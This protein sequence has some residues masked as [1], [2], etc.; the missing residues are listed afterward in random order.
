MDILL[1]HGYFLY[2]DPHERKVM[3]PYPPLG[4]LY[5]SSYLKKAGFSV[6]VFDSTFAT[7]DDF[8][9]RLAAERPAVVG[10]Y[11]NLMTKFNAL[12][13]IRLAKQ[14][15]A[16]IVLGGPEPPYYAREYI[17]CGADVVVRGEGETALAE[18][19]PHLIA[20]G[21]HDL[22]SILGIAYQRDDGR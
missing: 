6:G 2:D 4:I 7:L 17:D 20:K 21:L 15:G 22:D 16:Y 11:V 14:H 13:M 1:A 5:L 12:K 19:V 10:L 18:L 3:K 8:A 9:A